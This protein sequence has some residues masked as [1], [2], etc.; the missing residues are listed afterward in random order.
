MSEVGSLHLN[1]KRLKEELAEATRE[2]ASLKLKD[3]E[4]SKLEQKLAKMEAKVC[5]PKS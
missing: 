3:V 2:I 5:T 1:N 4:A